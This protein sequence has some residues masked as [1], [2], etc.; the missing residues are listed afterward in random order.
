M[1]RTN[2]AA[3]IR[4]RLL[5]RA[6]EKGED[7]QLLLTRYANAL[8]SVACIDQSNSIFERFDEASSRPDLGG[9]FKIFDRRRVHPAVVAK[10]AHLSR[11]KGYQR[12]L[13]P[14]EALVPRADSQALPG[15]AL[16]EN[17]VRGR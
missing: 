9:N 6:K 11:L 5:N 1:S 13:I 7:F 10:G 8:R 16:S 4:Q 15:N 14:S 17:D 3:S 12:A 2:L